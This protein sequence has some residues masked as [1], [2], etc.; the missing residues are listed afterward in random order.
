MGGKIWVESRHGEGSKFVFE[1]ELQSSCLNLEKGTKIFN[2]SLPKD[3]EE[4]KKPLGSEKRDALFDELYIAVASRRPKMCEPI[5]NTIE[6]YT[7][8]E[9]DRELFMRAKKLI[10]KYKF[11]EAKEVLNAR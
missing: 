10:E 5:I 7:L 6:E 3:I 11:S 4:N 9:K 2:E 8:S 1:V